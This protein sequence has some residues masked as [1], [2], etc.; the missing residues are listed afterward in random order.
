M[1]VGTKGTQF[2]KLKPGGC[3]YLLIKREALISKLGE[4]D[5]VKC[6]NLVILSF[7]IGV[8]QKF[9]LPIKQI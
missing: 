9:S 1:H 2:S 6:E 5:N 8:K 4:M 7:K 3:Y